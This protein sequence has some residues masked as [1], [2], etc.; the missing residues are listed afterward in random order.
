MQEYEIVSVRA[1]K[2][3]GDACRRRVLGRVETNIPLIDL[4]GREL[5]AVHDEKCD[6]PS[7]GFS[8]LPVYDGAVFEIIRYL[9]KF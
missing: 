3:E 9:E 1:R 5:R 8:D 2:R 7:R 6:G 4:E